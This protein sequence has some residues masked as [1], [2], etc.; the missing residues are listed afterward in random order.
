MAKKGLI[1][2]SMLCI[3]VIVGVGVGYWY[4]IIPKAESTYQELR[5][6]TTTSVRDTKLL[7]QL[8]P[9]FFEKY[10]INL[11]WIAV[12][13][14]Q[15]LTNAG[16]GDGDAVFV[17]SPPDE[18]VFI[19]HSTANTAKTYSGKGIMRVNVAENYFVI[20]GPKE[21]PAGIKG[22][23]N[24]TD[25]MMKIYNTGSTFISRGDNSGT[26]SK[27]K[28]LWTLTKITDYATKSWYKSAG[29]GMAAVIQMAQNDKAY[30][31]SDYGTWLSVRNVSTNLELMSG[32]NDENLRNIYSVICVDP[33]KFAE[34]AIKFDLAKKFIYF[35]LTDGQEIME[36]FKI[37]GES[38]FTPYKN[39]TDTCICGS[40]KCEVENG[41]LFWIVFHVQPV[42][43]ASVIELIVI[44][45]NLV[46]ETLG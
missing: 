19:N 2:G 42:I 40:E 44:C 29:Q 14:G 43:R 37:D 28:A 18:I 45:I 15:A 36:N 20:I 17:H 8:R 5:L 46:K 12:G 41:D 4:F 26:H 16:N 25:A 22:T 27:E 39:Y 24:V 10:N 13:T 30:T 9:A 32:F 1:I 31:L 38:V 34:N 33:D 3:L 7:D 23:A 21:D 35:M 11:T 6:Q